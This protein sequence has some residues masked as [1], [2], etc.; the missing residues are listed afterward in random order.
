MYRQLEV[1]FL[2]GLTQ[3]VEA[4]H[5]TAQAV[6]SLRMVINSAH[7]VFH[8][9]KLTHNKKLQAKV[10][11]AEKSGI[12][13]PVELKDSYLELQEICLEFHYMSVSV[14]KPVNFSP[15]HVISGN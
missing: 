2:S 10:F 12:N 13:L 5:L 14:S 1:L 8:E 3:Q 15:K 4:L 9:D 6:L 7:S 11:H